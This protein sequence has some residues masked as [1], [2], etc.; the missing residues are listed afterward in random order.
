MFKNRKTTIDPDMTDT[1][2]GEGTVF[3]GKIKS[4]ASIRIEGR[5]EGDI[6]CGGDVTVGEKGSARSHIRARHVIVAGSVTGNVSASG[7]LTIKATGQLYGNLSAQELSIE[8]GGIFQG[9]SKMDTGKEPRSP[10]GETPAGLRDAEPNALSSAGDE[11][12]AVLKTW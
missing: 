1:L 3:E 6:E 2:I 7:K 5:L 11:T 12:A 9:T 4:E 10:E 8:P